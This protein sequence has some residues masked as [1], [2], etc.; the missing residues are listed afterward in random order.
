M[1]QPFLYYSQP[2]PHGSNEVICYVRNNGSYTMFTDEINNNNS[3]RRFNNLTIDK[4]NE[5]VTLELVGSDGTYTI[6]L[7]TEKVTK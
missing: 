3:T 2:T 4:D 7:R 5:K 6:D 1:Q